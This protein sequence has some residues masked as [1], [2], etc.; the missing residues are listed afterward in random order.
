MSTPEWQF[1]VLQE[2]ANYLV[3]KNLNEGISTDEE[4]KI[5]QFNEEMEE[6]AYKNANLDFVLVQQYQQELVTRRND[7]FY[8]D[9]LKQDNF[10]DLN[11]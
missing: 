9:Y 7:Y 10:D 6:I 3:F 11:D 1:A 4:A 5:D 8:E 2:A